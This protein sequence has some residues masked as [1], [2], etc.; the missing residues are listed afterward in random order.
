M[1]QSKFSRIPNIFEQRLT[2]HNTSA[3][4]LFALIRVRDDIMGDPFSATPSW[5]ASYTMPGK[6]PFTMSGS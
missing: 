2:P 4:Q 6:Q 5:D 3:P 1:W